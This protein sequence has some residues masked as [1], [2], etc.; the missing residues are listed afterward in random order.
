MQPCQESLTCFLDLTRGL[1][2]ARF[3]IKNTKLNPLGTLFC[4]KVNVLWWD[5]WLTE[6]IITSAVRNK[7]TL[8]TLVASWRQFWIKRSECCA[9]PCIKFHFNYLES[10][11]KQF[12]LV[13]C[14]SILSFFRMISLSTAKFLMNSSILGLQWKSRGYFDDMLSSIFEYA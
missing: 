3:E 7:K 5:V 8:K 9:V 12:S 14:L 11:W 10:L 1:R 4:N 2:F 13:S 6:F